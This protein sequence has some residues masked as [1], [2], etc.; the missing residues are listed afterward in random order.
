MRFVRQ[1]QPRDVSQAS[2][3]RRR[4]LLKGVGGAAPEE[5]EG[6]QDGATA[7]ME[8]EPEL[9]TAG[10]GASLEGTA[11]GAGWHPERPTA[12]IVRVVEGT[13]IRGKRGAALAGLRLRARLVGAHPALEAPAPGAEADDRLATW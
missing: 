11:D 7:D 6:S 5:E 9:E 8:A 3:E 4:E 1:S 13:Q 2:R 12:V 10:D